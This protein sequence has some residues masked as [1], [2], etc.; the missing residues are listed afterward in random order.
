[1]NKTETTTKDDRNRDNLLRMTDAIRRFTHCLQIGDFD[2]VPK[3]Y[4]EFT[5][6][7]KMYG[8]EATIRQAF[9]REMMFATG[10]PIKRNI[11]KDAIEMQIGGVVVVL[12]CMTRLAGID[13]T[14]VG[15]TGVKFFSRRSL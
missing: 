6:M 9:S 5:D 3:L 15:Y 1:M 10:E 14:D 4:F 8:A 13:G 12:R 7:S 11:D 2:V